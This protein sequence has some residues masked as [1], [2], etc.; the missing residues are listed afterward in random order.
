[1]SPRLWCAWLSCVFLPCKC[2]TPNSGHAVARPLLVS[3]WI[4][5]FGQLRGENS[6]VCSQHYNLEHLLMDAM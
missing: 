1:M 3:V 5:N 2:L 6:G 4:D